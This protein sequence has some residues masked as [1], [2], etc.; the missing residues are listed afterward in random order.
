MPA[1]GVLSTSTCCFSKSAARG[2]GFERSELEVEAEGWVDCRLA[3]VIDTA[4]NKDKK[5]N[6]CTGEAFHRVVRNERC[7]K[8]T[9]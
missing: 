2:G 1:I 7:L 8:A 3:I 5:L 4:Q 6:Q 9:Q